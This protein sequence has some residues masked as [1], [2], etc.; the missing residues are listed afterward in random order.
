ME[1]PKQASY[2]IEKIV[3]LESNFRREIAIDFEG[4]PPT[5]ELHVDNRSSDTESEHFQVS[6]V[7]TLKAIQ[8]EKV[9]FQFSVT[10]IGIFSK[11]GDT[12]LSEE[13]FKKV[14]APAIIFPFVREHI[15]I[16]AL[17]AGVGDVLLPLSISKVKRRVK[18]SYSILC[19]PL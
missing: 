9:V 1:S 14:N 15:A 19:L 7:V 8:K 12:S 16:T 3:L 4:E 6:L 17:K 10:T 13:T 5:N 18:R 2:R 11:Q